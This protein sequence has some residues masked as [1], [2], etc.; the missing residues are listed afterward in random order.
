MTLS[1]SREK[2]RRFAQAW[3]DLRIGTR[4]TAGVTT[5]LLLTVIVGPVGRFTLESQSRSQI[6]ANQAINLISTLRAA[7]QDTMVLKVALSSD[8]STSPTLLLAKRLGKS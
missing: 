5:I 6:L 8:K 1:E 2:L 3:N 7:R 4:S